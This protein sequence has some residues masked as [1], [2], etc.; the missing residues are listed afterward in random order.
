MEC[1][2]VSMT[3][4]LGVREDF[5]TGM[6][7]CARTPFFL[8]THCGEIDLDATRSLPRPLLGPRS[9]NQQAF[10]LNKEKTDPEVTAALR[11]HKIVYA[12]LNKDLSRVCLLYTSPS[13]RD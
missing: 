5:M 7:M 8:T 3:G 9:L 2:V 1:G 10:E 6:V 4:K 11:K 12:E 13:P